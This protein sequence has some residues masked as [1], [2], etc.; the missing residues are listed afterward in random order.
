MSSS[1]AGSVEPALDNGYFRA[2]LDGARIVSLRMD[3][4]GK[5]R[6][7]PNRV[8]DLGFADLA[9]GDT[10]RRVQAK[11]S[12][13]IERLTATRD[14]NLV[15]PDGGLAVRLE[16]GRSLGQS[17]VVK[18]GHARRI[19]AHLPT[20]HTGD[21]SATLSLRR[22]GPGGA[23]IARRRI[24][25]AEDNAW[26][27]LE[28]EPQGP[29]RYYIELSGA[30]GEIG[31]WCGARRRYADGQA[32]ADGEPVADMERAIRVFIR[33]SV[34]PA[35]FAIRAE[36]PRLIL[37]TIVRPVEGEEERERPL[38]MKLHWDN[39]G[40]DVSA[41][42]VPFFRFYSG[43]MRYMPV[44][45]LKRWA[46]R[47]GWYERGLGPTAW[48]EADGTGNH[49][50]RF[51]GRDLR[52]RWRVG[53]AEGLVRCTTSPIPE[54]SAAANRV[55]IEVLPRDDAL[56]AHWPRFAGP[57]AAQAHDAN[58]FFYERA[59]SYPPI[60]GAAPWHEWNAITRLWQSGPHLE[61]LR[62]D[63]ERYPIDDE[64]Y[65]HTW[66]G[67][68]GWPFPDN[69]KYD[70]RHFDTNARF[71]LACW[72][73]A[74]WT[75]DLGFLRRQAERLRSAMR[76]QLTV[77]R[78]EEGLILTDSPDVNG[79]H[80]GVGNNYWDILPFGHLDAYANAVWYA[81]LEAMA[82]IEEM[83]ADPGDGDPAARE[84]AFYR[85][86][87]AK[88]REAYNRTF[89]DDD[90][91][92]YI[93]CI[94]V[95]G[96]RHDYGFTFVNLEAMA[97]G[98]ADAA[99]ARRLYR[100]MEEEPTHSGEADTYTRWIFAPRATTIH[101]PPWDPES[102]KLADVPQEPWWFFGWRG[103]PWDE[104]CQDGGAILYTS[105]FDLMARTRHLG[106]DNAWRRWEEILGRWRLPDRLC[107][108]PPLFRGEHPQQ[109]HP[110]SVGLDIPFPESGLVPC[111]LLYGVMGIEPTSRGLEIA[112]RL[113]EALPW[114]EAHN[115]AYH[116]L[117]L[118][119]RVEKDRVAIRW[120]ENG[121]ARQW[122][123]ELDADGRALF[124]VP[125]P[126]EGMGDPPES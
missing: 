109:V 24:E 97:Y 82:Q 34:G 21:S 46:E 52:L 47:D 7:G 42:S 26:Q 61:S 5:G 28:F 58:L 69:S 43:E 63:W 22:D 37:E 101:N 112:P 84:P 72:R 98:L 74:A 94:D 23:V 56:P 18:G 122:R 92:R 10:T 121:R 19:E 107:G 79:R 73:Y 77:L 14:D 30:D 2:A 27:P 25:N 80:L 117:D 49:D 50:L 70:T 99:R 8:I 38:D 103:T 41:D 75:G 48:V 111:W 125:A 91:G 110:G 81:S 15:V 124:I 35:D 86:L 115:V 51:H 65:A 62:Q 45:Q 83:L 54:G 4:E 120:N 3:P 95:D 89:W 16:P 66:G 17:F 59:F 11:G 6:Y 9:A 36:G 40:Y 32:Y 71:I 123:H 126:G 108:G 31:W 13:T 96:R 116:G 87:A 53:G 114:F 12:V 55:T 105:Y 33:R 102:G 85:T 78:G 29:G 93:G 104:Q 119:I 57:H 76:Y 90:K 113:P 20:W 39:T 64:G 118:T 44:Q 1:F 88:A 106:P 60:W 67:N 68:A 100:W